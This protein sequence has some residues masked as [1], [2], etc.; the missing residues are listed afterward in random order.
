MRVEVGATWGGLQLP[1]SQSGELSPKFIRVCTDLGFWFGFAIWEF[2][3][4]DLGELKIRVY[5]LGKI[6]GKDL[7]GILLYSMYIYESNWHSLFLFFFFLCTVMCSW[8]NTNIRPTSLKKPSMQG[9]NAFLNTNI[10]PISITL[11]GKFLNTSALH[12]E[13]KK[14]VEMAL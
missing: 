4:L 13:I 14:M 5:N 8:I 9:H 2:R 7:V 6:H 10:I 3:V 1:R 11:S 12:L